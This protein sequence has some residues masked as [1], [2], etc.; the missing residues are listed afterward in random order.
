MNAYVRA[1]L[2]GT[3]LPYPS[4]VGGCWLFTGACRTRYGW[5][6]VVRIWRPEAVTRR[7]VCFTPIKASCLTRLQTSAPVFSSSDCISSPASTSCISTSSYSYGSP[8]VSEVEPSLRR[9]RRRS[10]VSPVTH[11]PPRKAF[12]V[13]FQTPTPTPPVRD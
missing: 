4:L 9:P 12:E 11:C 1:T 8:A 2:A 7:Y 13:G 6:A 10:L 3:V 5:F